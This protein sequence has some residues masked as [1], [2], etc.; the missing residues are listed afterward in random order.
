MRIA[1][2]VA[3]KGDLP[4]GPARLIDINSMKCIV[5]ILAAVFM[6]SSTLSYG[7]RVDFCL[8]SSCYIN[9][10][11][12]IENLQS[13]SA[14]DSVDEVHVALES[15][16]A[17]VAELSENSQSEAISP[18]VAE[19]E[20]QRE[21][22]W[23]PQLSGFFDVVSAYEN[24]SFGSGRYELGQ[25]ELDLGASPRPALDIAMAICYSSD[26]GAFSV[27]AV[28]A[29]LKLWGSGEGFL[30]SSRRIEEFGIIVGQFDV[31]FG[32]D[33][34]N[35]ASIDRL[36]ISAP[37]VC[38]NTHGLWNDV[39][40][41]AYF[42]AGWVNAT[43]F[44]VNGFNTYAE[45]THHELNLSTGEYED[46]IETIDTSPRHAY[47]MRL[48]FG[49]DEVLEIGISGALGDNRSHKPEMLIWGFDVS[50]VFLGL[51]VRSEFIT[52]EL[53]RS[54]A[55]ERRRGFY[56]EGI[57]PLGDVYLISRYGGL[58]STGSDEWNKQLS[59]GGGYKIGEEVRLSAEFRHDVKDIDLLAIQMVFGF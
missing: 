23:T 32:L 54:I 51:N 31:P 39:G 17:S 22:T 10:F 46:V 29:D 7:Q 47:G 6:F 58:K 26:D 16:E 11:S 56:V 15:D 19:P 3:R 4:N 35:Y 52:E 2:R 34:K 27:G 25:V 8:T 38:E 43:A 48:G 40:V 12:V 45:I 21:W 50:T 30:H 42:N 36:L 24:A 57:Q 53:N 5:T 41:Q 55:A 37:E 20:I 44:A 18:E 49:T 28:Y 14:I 9:T 13:V 33:W 1:L 59:V